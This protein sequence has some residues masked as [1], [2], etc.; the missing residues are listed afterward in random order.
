MIRQSL[1][2]I[3]G[4]VP[5]SQM[6]DT[7]RAAE[8]EGLD[9]VYVVE[10]YRS[11]FVPLAAIAMATQRIA[12][13]P[14]ILNAYGRSPFLTGLSAIDLDELSGGRLVLGIG[15]GNIH[16]N[17]D[18]QGL[19]TARP[20][21]KMREYVEI[22]RQMVRT[23]I[24]GAVRYEGQIHSMRWEPRVAPIRTSLPVW[25]AA[26]SPKMVKAAATVSDG[27][28]M[29]VLMSPEYIRDRVRP[30]AIEAA[31]AAGRDPSTIAF[32]MGGLVAV[33][34]DLDRARTAIKATISSFYHPIPHPY[35]DFLLRE[36][37][38]SRAADACMKFVP[39]GKMQAAMDQIDDEVV[40]RLAFVG[41]P[42]QCATRL[43]AYEGSIDEVIFLN[44]GGA[45]AS[46]LSEAHRP[47]MAI[48]RA[49]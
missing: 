6:V 22:V 39:E 30:P 29:G 28:A 7:A 47:V 13:G 11:G 16:I 21:T 14:Y 33:D 2:L 12:I 17:R 23:P 43:K 19:E 46:S 1:L 37:G 32:P 20:I 31:Q 3:G 18:F 24:G 42:A 4:G 45:G 15:P 25:M 35:Y 10:A 36:H 27:V 8:G 48:K 44:V 40:D 41:T 34:E 49:S 9:G 26:I 5:V 38:Y